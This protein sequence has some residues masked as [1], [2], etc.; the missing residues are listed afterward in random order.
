MSANQI[1]SS[2]DLC[3]D[4]LSINIPHTEAGSLKVKETCPWTS[5]T[6]VTSVVQPSHYEIAPSK[7]AHDIEWR[8]NLHNM[9][10]RKRNRHH[11]PAESCVI[12][13]ACRSCIPNYPNCTVSVV[14]VPVETFAHR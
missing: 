3:P 9:P 5:R 12:V 6:F 4:L 1:N 11:T 14:T 13:A 2:V 10:H 7:T 8:Y